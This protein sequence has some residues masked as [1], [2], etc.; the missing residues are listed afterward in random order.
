MTFFI[1]QLCS[2]VLVHPNRHLKDLQVQLIVRWFLI[3][4][5]FA[6]D[7]LFYLQQLLRCTE[8]EDPDF[9]NM[10]HFAQL[11]SGLP[12]TSEPIIRPSFR[13]SEPSTTIKIRPV[14]CTLNSQSHSLPIDS[15]LT[16]L[17]TSAHHQIIMCRF[18]YFSLYLTHITFD[19]YFCIIYQN[20]SWP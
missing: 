20:N 11:C 14:T 6:H 9:K 17:R 10:T 5:I 16:K 3:Q 12:R 15:P 13:S 18:E 19:W 7:S 2:K 1:V 4:V 8:E